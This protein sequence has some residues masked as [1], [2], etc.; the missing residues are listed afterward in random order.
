M[1]FECQDRTSFLYQKMSRLE[2]LV[3]KMCYVKVRKSRKKLLSWILLKNEHWGNFIYWKLPQRSFFGRIQ[4]ALICFWDLLTFTGFLYKVCFYL[5]LVLF[6]NK[7]VSKWDVLRFYDNMK[8]CNPV[9]SNKNLKILMDI[10]TVWG[11]H[12]IITSGL[13]IFYPFLRPVDI[14]GNLYTIQENTLIT[15][16]TT[17]LCHFGSNS[18][19]LWPKNRYS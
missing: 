3:N 10:N 1:L 6:I 12:P 14:T 2:L 17:Y 18:F 5:W 11:T 15:P 16:Y 4:D 7:N 13:D 19:V 8:W 9:N